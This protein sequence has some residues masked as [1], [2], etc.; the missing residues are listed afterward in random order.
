LKKILKARGGILQA[1]WC[2][3]RSCEDKLK[4]DT[5]TKIINIPF[6]QGKITSSCIICGNKAKEIVNIAKS[7]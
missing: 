4:E 2:G 5:G 7:Y 3:G 6:K 1:P